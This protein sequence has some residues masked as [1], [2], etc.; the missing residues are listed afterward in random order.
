MSA[1]SSYLT[2]A[3]FLKRA[4]TRTVARL[5]SD[6]DTAVASGSVATNDNLIAALKSASGRFEAAYLSNTNH[7]LAGLQAIIDEDGVAANYIYEILTRLTL[8]YLYQR[9]PNMELPRPDYF[10]GLDWDMQ[11]I[12]FGNS[13][14]A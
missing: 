4:D 6:S 12:A 2:A 8:Y 9:R 7:T 10:K 14:L 1:A 11:A 3:E 5:I 13:V